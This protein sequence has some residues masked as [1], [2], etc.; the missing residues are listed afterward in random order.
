M[1]WKVEQLTAP[2]FALALVLLAVVGVVSYRNLERQAEAD[3]MVAHTQEVLISAES[4]LSIVKD[5]ETGQRGYLITGDERHLEPYQS[6]VANWRDGLRRLRELTADNASQQRRLDEITP[7][8]ED[9]L[10]LIERVVGLRRQGDGEAARRIVLGGEGRR[11]MD[12]LRRRFSEIQTEERRLLSE[13]Q[14]ARSREWRAAV[15]VVLGWLLAAGVMTLANFALERELLRRR[16]AEAELQRVNE[17]LE[18]RIAARTSE[19]GEAAERFRVTLSSIGD[20]VIVTDD[21]GRVTFMNTV[22][23]ALTGWA[24]DEAAG[25]PLGEV[26]HVFNEDTRERVEHPVAKIIREGVI[27]GLANPT[28]LRARDGSERPIDDSGAPVRDD[29]G[30]IAGVVLVFHDVTEERRA[31]RALRESEARF[32]ILADSSPVLIWVNGLEGCE[33][34]NRA[35][36]EFVGVASAQVRNFD[37]TPFV[38]PEDREAYV[39][40]YLAAFA[41]R[42]PFAAQFR[43]RRADGEYRWMKSAGLPRFSEAGEFQGY[44]GSTFDIT[45]IKQAEEALRES[46]EAV[47]RLNENLERLV[48]ERTARLEEVVK[49]LDAFAHSVSHDLRA[50]LRAMHGHATALLEDY[51]NKLDEHA[52]KYVE[53]IVAASERMDTLIQDLLAYSRLTRAEITPQPVDLNSAVSEARAQI[54]GALKESGAE[55]IVEQ[56]LPTVV[57]HRATLTQALTNLL[58]NAVKFVAP[59]VAPRVRV[60]AEE[61]DGRARLWVEDNGIGI[62]PEHRDRVFQIFE[63]LHSVTTYSGTGIGLAIVRKGVERM[64]GSAGVESEPGRGSRFWIELP[65]SLGTH[66]S[67]VL[68]PG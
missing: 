32:R 31:A 49:E 27:A 3:A 48:A 7:L 54:E 9:R 6:A 51:A 12:E 37:W 24:F 63:R 56:P 23:E 20:A 46:G 40:A 44:V 55:L 65:S 42:E 13:H 39:N 5:A 33:F 22:A 19:L 18:E 53:R 45:D 68:P 2:A 62:A 47:R 59:G 61:R 15:F 4:L 30:N 14:A 8:V 41:Q 64:G 11:L 35:Y 29:D 43:F 67:S 58:S 21:Q 60:R 26:F 34:V 50:P 16:R 38:H 28:V 36:S 52:R 10:R 25:R 57:G 66:A 17:G 1:E